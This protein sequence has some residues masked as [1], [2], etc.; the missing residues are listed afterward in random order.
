MKP[1][2]ALPALIALVALP[3]WFAASPMSA[4]ETPTQPVNLDLVSGPIN[5]DGMPDGWTPFGSTPEAY[6]VGVEAGVGRTDVL[7]IH[8]HSLP[9][10]EEPGY[11]MAAQGFQAGNYLAQRVRFAGWVRVGQIGEGWAGLWLRIDGGGDIL[12]FDNMETR[13]LRV[14]G[15]WVQVDI[16]VDVPLQAEIVYIGSILV[17]AGEIWA[18][19][20]TFEIVG[21]EVPLSQPA[22]SD[23]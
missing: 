19:D 22:P 13:G 2:R 8:I 18:D 23:G 14:P 21:D 7:S 1:I 20:F 15:E 16:V 17:G 5:V 12:V 6:Q 9:E 10:A 11:M 3:A 4:Q